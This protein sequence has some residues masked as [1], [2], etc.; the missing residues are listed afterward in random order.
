MAR[1]P[2]QVLAGTSHQ[3]QLG[4]AL[5]KDVLSLLPNLLAHTS[6]LDGSTMDP[7][8]D[9]FFIPCLISSAGK[10]FWTIPG[11]WHAASPI[12]PAAHSTTQ[13]TPSIYH[14]PVTT[15]SHLSGDRDSPATYTFW[16]FSQHP[17]HRRICP[18]RWVDGG[19]LWASAKGFSA[20]L[21]FQQMTCKWNVGKVVSRSSSGINQ[22]RPTKDIKALLVFTIWEF[23]HRGGLNVFSLYHRYTWEEG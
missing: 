15:T 12:L 13:P 2:R 4:E 3:G 7:F 11:S 16:S 10:E 5:E 6:H 17:R 9:A 23:G 21:S 19:G 18:A 1:C 22:Q 8:Q 20:R 14:P